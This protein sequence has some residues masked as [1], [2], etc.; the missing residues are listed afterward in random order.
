MTPEVQ[1]YLDS[2]TRVGFPE[3]GLVFD[4]DPT[5][6]TLFGIDIRWYG[7]IIAAGMLLAFLYCF[8]RMTSFGI[9]PDRAIDVVIGGVVGAIIGARLYYVAFSD[10]VTIAD[11]FRIRNGGLAIYG[12]LIGAVVVGIVIMKF[13]KVKILPML[14]VASLGFL[15]GQ[16]VGRWGNFVNQEAYG[17]ITTLPW[18]MS[19]YRIQIELGGG[20]YSEGL[21][22]A[23]PCFLYESLWCILGFVILH[24][25]SKKR[26]FDGQVFLS[27][28]AW[29]GAGRFVIEGLRTDSLMLGRLRVSQVLAGALVIT[30]IVLLLVISS[31]YKRSGEPAVL[32]VNTEESEKLI[33]EDEQKYSKNN[34]KTEDAEESAEDETDNNDTEDNENG[35]DN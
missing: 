15:I 30:A 32:Y 16:A 14:D 17:D 10:D 26:S 2:P 12:G 22:M 34:K 11:F 20:A 9:S 4:I 3:T 27:Y 19:S 24:F 5:A 1:F 7:I 13:R 18:G 35:E 6:F 33:S 8:K 25:F 31:K 29:Y 21:V 28:V 23:H